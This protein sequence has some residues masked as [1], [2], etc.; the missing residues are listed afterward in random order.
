MEVITAVATDPPLQG[1]VC[2]R[3]ANSEWFVGRGAF[4]WT[5]TWRQYSIRAIPSVLVDILDGKTNRG[6]RSGNF[7][8][9]WEQVFC[10][11][12]N[13]GGEGMFVH[14]QKPCDWM[15]IDN[16]VKV[17]CCCACDDIESIRRCWR[18]FKCIMEEKKIFGEILEML[19]FSSCPCLSLI[20]S[21]RQSVGVTP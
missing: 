6:Q 16:M 4:F 11:K 21:S 5:L 20:G 18:V 9:I 15:F 13:S 1:P 12:T 17:L 10:G 3:L 19:F 14:N 8:G 7:L 2:Q